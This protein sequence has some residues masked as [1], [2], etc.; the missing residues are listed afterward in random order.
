MSLDMLAN[1]FKLAA[2]RHFA[3]SQLYVSLAQQISRDEA[4][5]KVAAKAN[6]GKFP[7]LLFLAAIHCLLLENSD[8]PLARFFP[9][10]A[11]K[12]IPK[13]D[14]YPVFRSFVLEFSEQITALIQEANVNM[15]VIKRSACLRA[16]LIKVAA[17]MKW[18][19]LHLVDI[20]CSA[21]FNL[22]LDHWRITYQ[23]AGEVG[24]VESSVTFSIE[25][26]GDSV[27]PLGD[28]PT[29][30]SRTGIDL[31]SFDLSNKEHER[32]LLGCL[33]PEDLESFEATKRA[34]PVL[35]QHM[36][37]LVAGDAAILLA[38]VLQDIPE[39]EPVVVMHSLALHLMAPRQRQA[40]YRTIRQASAI[41]PIAKI[42]MELSGAHSALTV[43]TG[44]DME[45]RVVGE[46]DD[47]ATWMSWA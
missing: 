29:L 12:P 39:R 7:P 33:I 26:R 3:A 15:T 6:P 44:K 20:G 11:R 14:P 5:L 43:A 9:T 19:K 27:P 13:I 28:T 47:N 16:L 25:L 45:Q 23:G 46:A 2:K 41:R 37:R 4:V 35:R 18:E 17:E 10:T 32:W 38:K 42:G 34:F 30:L 8:R 31:D 1:T 22:L 21:G 40:V 36:P 24:P